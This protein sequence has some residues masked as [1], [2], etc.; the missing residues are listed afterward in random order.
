MNMSLLEG[1]RVTL[2]AIFGLQ[3]PGGSASKEEA[4]K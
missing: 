2:S 4:M 1:S 3:L